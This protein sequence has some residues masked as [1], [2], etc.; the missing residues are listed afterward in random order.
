[1]R[2]AM[3]PPEA[4]LVG[5]AMGQRESAAKVNGLRQG[6]SRDRRF[7]YLLE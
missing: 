7:Y 4:K 3:C 2:R 5:I 6:D 1:M